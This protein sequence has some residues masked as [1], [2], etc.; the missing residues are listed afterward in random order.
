MHLNTPRTRLSPVCLLWK[1]I[2][3]RRHIR[4]TP[5]HP[6]LLGKEELIFQNA[7]CELYL[8]TKLNDLGFT[9]KLF[10]LILDFL[11]SCRQVEGMSSITSA[12]LIL[13][14]EAPQDCILSPLLY[15]Q[16]IHTCVSTDQ[17]NLVV[18]FTDNT[19]MVG[20]IFN[21]YEMTYRKEMGNLSQQ[22]QKSNLLL[23]M[24]KTK[25]LLMDYRRG[26]A[27]LALIIIK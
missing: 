15:S 22:R 17:S 13:N 9:P 4:S 2:H 20:L 18:R 12:P 8:F 10:S 24:A 11:I 14:T 26:R 23:N 5:Q 27:E 7:F 19:T 6:H 21:R 1:Q 3:S 16:Y 25:E